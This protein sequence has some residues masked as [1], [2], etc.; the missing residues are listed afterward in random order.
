M[1]PDPPAKPQPVRSRNIGRNAPAPCGP[2]LKY[3]RC[4]GK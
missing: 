4:G 2:H 1:P 3:K